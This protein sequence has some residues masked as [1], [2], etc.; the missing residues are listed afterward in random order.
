MVFYTPL[1][2]TDQDITSRPVERMERET[3]EH[4]SAQEGSVTAETP[5]DSITI[6]IHSV[7]AKLYLNRP[8]EELIPSEY[9]KKADESRKEQIETPSSSVTLPLTYLISIP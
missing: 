4:K 9:S 7:T 1:F 8:I 5:D 6:P 3:E 2:E